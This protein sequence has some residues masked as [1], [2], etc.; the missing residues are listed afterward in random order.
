MK[1]TPAGTI[2]ISF[3][4]NRLTVTD[5]GIGIRPEDVP[6]IFSKGYTG[7]NG[8]LD[9]RASG[10]GLY[11]AKSGGRAEHLRLQVQSRVGKARR[12]H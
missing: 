12:L 9:G 5:T 10:I 4:N 3:E 7:Q 2:H 6:R 1:Y 8:R 11:L